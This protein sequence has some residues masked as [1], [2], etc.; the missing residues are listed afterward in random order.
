LLDRCD[1]LQLLDAEAH[2]SQI[3]AILKRLAFIGG[4]GA[5]PVQHFLAQH[6]VFGRTDLRRFRCREGEIGSLAKS[7]SA[8]S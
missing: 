8:L 4:E 3:P 2:G 5:E 7:G 1:C 6:F